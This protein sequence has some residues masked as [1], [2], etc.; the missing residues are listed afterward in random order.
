MKA[1]EDR[2][3]EVACLLN[4]AFCGQVIYQCVRGFADEAGAPMPYPLAFVILPLVLH[5]RTRA[6]MDGG[7]RHLQVWLNTHQPIKIGL[8]ERARTLVP[9]TREALLF[10]YQTRTVTLREEDAAVAITGPLRRARRRFEPG[11]ETRSCLNKAGV[12]GKWFA[13]TESP[14]TIYVSLGLMP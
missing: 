1:W 12:L 7:T 8:A 3:P 5:P 10:L 9:H 11:D 6:T 13:R 2:P 14:A 4:P